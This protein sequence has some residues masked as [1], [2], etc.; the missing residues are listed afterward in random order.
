MTY[1]YD[2]LYGTTPDAL[3]APTQIFV[4]FFDRQDRP[5]L[6]VL[7][8]GCGQGRDALFI[9]RLGHRV[10]GVDF[11]ANGIRDMTKAAA[12][13]DLSVEGIVADITAFAPP[14][15]FDVVLIDRTLH[16]LDE[17]PRLGALKRLIDHVADQGWVLIADEKSNIPGFKQIFDAHA[18][19]WTT[20]IAK[21]GTL[22]MQRSAG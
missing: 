22:F 4:D 11:A 13:E 12:A 7:D 5:N 17:Q 19:S 10:V 20:D 16:M 18:A 14:G 21:G 1:D 8:V 2:A 3:G 9:A 15:I 6:R